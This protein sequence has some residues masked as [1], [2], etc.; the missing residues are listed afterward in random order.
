MLPPH[1]L[2]PSR[3]LIRSLLVAGI[4]SHP[5]LL[6]PGL[7]ILNFLSKPRGPLFSTD[8]NPILHTTLKSFLYSHFCA[9]ENASEVKAT[10][11]NMKNMGFRGV[12]LTYAKET[13]GKDFKD[14]KL[15]NDKSQSV[16]S[17]I[18]AWHQGVLQTVR[19][20]GDGDFLA[21][22]LTGAGEAVTTA[23]SAGKLLPE[24]MESALLDVCDEAISRHVNVFLDAEQHYV[25]SGID[26]VALNLMRRYNRGGV[27]VV[28]S[29]YQ[30]YLK[31]APRI[32]LDHLHK[33]RE[34]RFVIGIK[35]V[36]GA[37]M[38]TEP[39]HLIHDTKEETDLFYDRIAEGLIQG[40][41]ASWAQD[42]TFNSPKLELFLATHNL[43][44][45]LKAQKLQKS[46]MHAQLPLI[47]IQYGQLLGMADEVSL[48]LLQLN[49]ED[50]SDKQLAATE[51][52]KCLTWGTLSDCIYYLLRRA[53][54][55]KDA[56]TRTLAEYN[57]LK[58]EVL[59]RM[60]GVFSS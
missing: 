51:V 18:T 41:Y 1:S 31:S 44:S 36:R 34:E 2:L 39:R 35:L 24:Q 4:T 5:F 25:Q 28:F 53:N 6:A 16:D 21:L 54:E 33:A 7:S 47:R 59:R 13:S 17:E 19:M 43:P 56:V 27:A 45:T 12:I 50:A 23:L 55:N 11:Q 3:M 32:L 9:G 29:T 14:D 40:Q 57:A 20:I 26:K 8:R 30:A 38:S 58:R 60:M 48:T 52:Y 49:Q 10:I 15:S 22:K 42:E 46:R 37:Y